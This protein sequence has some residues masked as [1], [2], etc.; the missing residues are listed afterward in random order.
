M[1]RSEGLGR[2]VRARS[3]S[4]QIFVACDASASAA[5]VRAERL[6]QQGG[7]LAVVAT[8]PVL[9][10]ALFSVQHLAAQHAVE[11]VARGQDPAAP[12]LPPLVVRRVTPPEL[13][14][15]ELVVVA[16]ASPAPAAPGQA[17]LLV[18]LPPEVGGVLDQLHLRLAAPR[19]LRLA[20][21]EG[22]LDLLPV[23]VQQVRLHVRKGRSDG[24]ASAAF[25]LQLLMILFFF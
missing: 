22:H 9:Q 7:L 21:A 4:V 16:A 12:V 23:H 24:L 13:R 14:G 1:V 6:P 15:Q 19:A 8:P 2:V 3:G 11:S 25:D 10:D 20:V 5:R 17:A 18:Q